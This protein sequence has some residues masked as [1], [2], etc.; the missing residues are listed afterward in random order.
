MIK[1][2]AFLAFLFAAFSIV[3]FGQNYPAPVEG[4]F[5]INDFHFEDG[6]VLQ[7]L[8]I[9]Y[10]TIGTPIKDGSGIV[11]N[12]V[13]IMHGTGGAGTQ[14]LSQGFAGQL[15]GPGQLLDATKYYIILPDGIGHGHSSKPSDGMHA[16]FPHY[17]YN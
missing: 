3:S 7:K 2:L 8:N 11:R 16:H 9:H 13:L 14:F 6:E 17:G 1:R 12:A 5:V 15:Y 10:R 4:D